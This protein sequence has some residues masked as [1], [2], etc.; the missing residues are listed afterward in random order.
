MIDVTIRLFYAFEACQNSP[1]KTPRMEKLN[2]NDATML[3]ITAITPRAIITRTSPIK[4]FTPLKNNF[5]AMITKK[6]IKIGQR[7]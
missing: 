7:T 2:K 3:A 6:I 5:R 4:N 1:A